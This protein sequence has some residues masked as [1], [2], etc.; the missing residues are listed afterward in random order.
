MYYMG[1]DV[2]SLSCDAVLIDEHARVLGSSVV[3]T[4]A[5]NREAISRAKNEALRGT[6]ILIDLRC[7]S[8]DEKSGLGP[9]TLTPGR[10]TSMICAS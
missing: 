7:V 10:K 6:G 8:R 3:P 5:R 4:G 9:G 2:G 1:I